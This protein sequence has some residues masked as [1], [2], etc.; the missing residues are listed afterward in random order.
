MSQQ[1]MS[2]SDVSDSD[3]SESAS[4][5]EQN[6]SSSR[7]KADAEQYELM[8]RAYAVVSEDMCE[9]PRLCAGGMLLEST[10]HTSYTL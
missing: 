7:L 2:K 1:D 4:D 3:G 6:D 9:S 8:Q 5:S 10:S